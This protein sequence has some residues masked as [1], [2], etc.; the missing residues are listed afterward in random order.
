MIMCTHQSLIQKQPFFIYYIYLFFYFFGYHEA[1]IFS[2][3]K[4]TETLK[5]KTYSDS[6]EYYGD[7]ILKQRLITIL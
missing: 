4:N 5:P 1:T 2:N 3:K 6:K 7:N